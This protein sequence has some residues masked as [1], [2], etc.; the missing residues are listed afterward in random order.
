G[1]LADRWGP[2]GVLTVAGVLLGVGTLGAAA[3]VSLWQLY[4]TVGIIVAIGAGG[5]STSVAAAVATRWVEGRGGL[6][7]GIT[8]GGMAA[9]QLL[10]VPVAM[11]LTVT[12]GWR[13]AFL[14]IGAGFLVIVLPVILTFIRN[15]PRDS[16]LRPYGAGEGTGTTRVGAPPAVE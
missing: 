6:G 7:L 5:A 13:S 10:V 11:W 9:G 12:W 16:G 8:G 3:V 15:D 2:R 1:R 4:L 14:A